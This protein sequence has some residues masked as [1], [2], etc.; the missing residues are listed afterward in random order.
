MKIPYVRED[1]GGRWL[2]CFAGCRFEERVFAFWCWLVVLCVACC[3]FGVAEKVFA[4]E[5]ER[6][7]ERLRFLLFEL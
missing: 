1:G 6:D 3:R 7:R 2:C 4:E 5:R